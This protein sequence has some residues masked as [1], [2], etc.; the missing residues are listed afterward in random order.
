MKT[1]ITCL[2]LAF[3]FIAQSQTVQRLE[4]F[5]DEDLGFGSATAVPGW[6]D[7]D[8]ASFN[9]T[10]QIPDTMSLGF[11]RLYFR[12][13]DNLGQWSHTTRNLI[14]VLPDQSVA[15]ITQA[16]YF[17]D[18]DMGFGLCTPIPLSLQ[19]AEITEQFNSAVN[20]LSPG[21][22]RLYTR[23]KD[24]NGKW[25]HTTRNLF[26]VIN[27]NVGKQIVA[28]EYYFMS[29]GEPGF[30]NAT[31]VNFA[32]PFADGAVTFSIDA[33]T[34]ANHINDD[35]VL[36]TLDC[37]GEWSHTVIQPTDFSVVNFVTGTIGSCNQTVCSG[38]IPTPCSV[39]TEAESF[40]DVSYQWYC[41]N[42]IQSPAGT[43]TSWTAIDGATDLTFAPNAVSQTVTYACYATSGIYEGWMN[44]A[45][46]IT[47]QANPTPSINLTGAA[48]SLCEGAAIS[49][50]ANGNNLGASPI[51]MWYVNDVLVP[52]ASNVFATSAYIDLLE[53]SVSAISTLACAVPDGAEANATFTVLPNVVPSIS[54]VAGTTEV[55]SGSTVVFNATATNTQAADNYTWFVNGVEQSETSNTLNLV[56]LNQDVSVYATI[57][58]SLCAINPEA[59][60]AT[61]YIA[62]TTTLTTAI[63]IEALD[64]SACEGDVLTFIATGS[65]LGDNPQYEWFIDGTFFEINSG[66]L[67][68]TTVNGMQMVSASATSTLECVTND[69]VSTFVEINVSEPVVPSIEVVA[70]DVVVCI[71]ESV[72]FTANAEN[73]GPQP[74]YEWYVGGNLESSNGATFTIDNIASD[75]N[76]YCNVTTSLCSLNPMAS[77]NTISVS[78]IAPPA[79]PIIT[80]VGTSLICSVADATS[81]EW[82]L[83]GVL[84]A[85][86][87]SADCL[88]EAQDNG[89]WTVVVF[90]SE[91][92]SSEST[93][94]D[95]NVNVE[96]NTLIQ[97]ASCYPNPLHNQL[98]IDLYSSEAL[99]V[100]SDMTGKVVSKGKLYKGLNQLNPETWSAGLYSL[101]IT[102]SLQHQNIIVIKQ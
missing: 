63:A 51:Y 57:E 69:T 85:D 38:E 48:G 99:Y 28:V 102:N 50:T 21:L 22:H 88:I 89:A 47:M 11:H 71:G 32:Q 86:C 45:M 30:D 16:E 80:Q 14:E 9:F 68:L 92:C 66:E 1:L 65:N 98:S 37:N 53:I 62:V 41:Q 70:S 87:T 40:V 64:V 42:G 46:Q 26:E 97:L 36:R 96:E 59:Q 17:I 29:S 4:Y 25:S 31:R 76:V 5:F 7:S 2:L 90:N 8:S 23:T 82:Y 100:I 94:F 10:I 75:A 49:L 44:G 93:V 83:S 56:N 101:E 79:V 12:T 15:V 13:Q 58:T 24:S 43:T 77:S 6:L 33:D 72:I 67:N 91:G 84:Y 81:Y 55:C 35:L 60:S 19:T 74:I 52:N 27:K 3:C 73:E 18:T 61:I 95:S 34:A 78:A 20:T 39:V 54:I